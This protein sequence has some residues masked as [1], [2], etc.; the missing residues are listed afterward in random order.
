[1]ASV[2]SS[3]TSGN[4]TSTKPCECADPGCNECGGLCEKD[5]AVRLYRVDMDD[6]TGVLFCEPCAA[7]ALASGVFTSL[8]DHGPL[9]TPHVVGMIPRDADCS[10]TRHGILFGLSADFSGVITVDDLFFGQP[11]GPNR[12]VPVHCQ[13]RQVSDEIADSA[14]QWIRGFCRGFLYR[15]E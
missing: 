11:Q 3:P 7:D 10:R 8:D 5:G 12:Q 6:A 15:A 9:E 2:V 1:M 13:S 14:Y 4:H